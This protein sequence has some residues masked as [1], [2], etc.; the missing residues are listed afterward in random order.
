MRSKTCNEICTGLNLH[1]RNTS[2]LTASVISAFSIILS[3][4]FR[5][6]LCSSLPSWLRSSQ[7]TQYLLRESDLTSGP[8]WDSVVETLRLYARGSLERMPAD[9][10]RE[11]LGLS[12]EDSMNFRASVELVAST[13]TTP[14]LS[15]SQESE[16]MPLVPQQDTRNHSGGAFKI[17]RSISRGMLGMGS[18]SPSLEKPLSNYS[19]PRHSATPPPSHFSSSLVPSDLTKPDPI[20]ASQLPP[21]HPGLH[22]TPLQR[23]IS[24]PS[25]GTTSFLTT[26]LRSPPINDSRPRTA[27]LSLDKSIEM[28][29]S[30]SPSL[31]SPSLS[32][33]LGKK[34]RGAKRQQKHY[35]AF[36]I[37]HN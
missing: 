13:S 31:P 34:R 15:S 4:P 29:S 20:V 14:P 37:E 10:E 25:S 3:H 12:L 36:I 28:N 17:L 11:S 26:S 30:S 33:K 32:G 21:P 1:T 24:E 5:S 7:N 35:T 27:T 19:P 22:P 18:S 9:E 23:S 16:P 2:S 8:G 6:S